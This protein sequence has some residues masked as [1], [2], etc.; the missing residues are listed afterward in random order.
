[1]LAM[2]AALAVLVFLC[3]AL[4]GY[5]YTTGSVSF[6]NTTLILLRASKGLNFSR[7]VLIN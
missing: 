2:P 7:G 1:M 4:P 3:Q 5:A 6:A